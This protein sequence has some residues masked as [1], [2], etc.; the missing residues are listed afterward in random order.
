MGIGS[1][2]IHR[3]KTLLLKG[4]FEELKLIKQG[5]RSLASSV[6]VDLDVS[7]GVGSAFQGTHCTGTTGKMAT[8]F[9]VR[10]NTGN[11]INFGKTQGIWFAQVVNSLILKVKDIS[12]FA[13]EISQK[14][15]EA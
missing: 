11:F 10:E 14:N 8:K 12:K 2:F 6:G 7:K 1:G 3:N 9:P 13:A 4:N 5:Y 15:F